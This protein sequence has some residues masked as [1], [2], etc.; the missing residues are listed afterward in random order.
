MIRL[1]FLLVGAHQLKSRWLFLA[2]L[3]LCWI[4]LGMAILYDIA[5]DGRLSVPLDTLAILLVVEGLVEIVAAMIVGLR[6]YWPGIW[7]GLGFI[8]IAFLVFDLP[9]DNNFLAS[10]LFGAAFLGDGIFR[11]A[12]SLVVRGTKWRREIIFG[13]I[14]IALSM[15][16]FSNWPFHHHIGVPFCFALLLSTWGISLLMMARQ[17]KLMSDNASVCVLPIFTSRSLRPW[18]EVAYYHPPFPQQPPKTPLQALVWTPVGSAS[19]VVTERR[20]VVDRYI[21]A[22][23]KDGVISTGHIALQLLPDLYISHNPFNYIDRDSANFRALLRAGEENDVPGRFFASMEEE[24]VDWSPPDQQVL[25]TRYNE[26]ALRNFW[27]VFSMDTTYNL[28]SR[29][30]SSTAIQALDV[31]IEGVMGRCSLPMMR[32]LL[33]PNFWMMGLLRGRAEEMTWTPGLAL[34]YVRLL[35]RVIEPQYSRA[36]HKRVREA[37]TVRKSLIKKEIRLKKGQKF[38]Q[39]DSHE[40]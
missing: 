29:N 4:A 30:C 35:Q 5:S 7:K 17:I 38:T 28:T 22:V 21:A 23:D 13:V 39:S 15:L 34:D 40:K 20:R 19:A 25:F 12:S 2:F 32:L 1:I 18:R 31:A 26:Q 36:W 6:I 8:F 16:I 33:D 9:W 11:I 27:Q 3:G 24:I 14:E 37:Y 10:V